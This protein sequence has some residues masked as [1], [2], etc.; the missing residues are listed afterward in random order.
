MRDMAWNG[1]EWTA[2][3]YEQGEGLRVQRGGSVNAATP[4][5]V[6]SAARWGAPETSRLP[7]VRFRCAW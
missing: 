7:D 1:V 3:R 5:D 2:D 4:A 6:R